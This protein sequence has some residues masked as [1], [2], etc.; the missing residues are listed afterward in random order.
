[1]TREEAQ[2]LVGTRRVMPAT[3]SK[4]KR[5]PVPGTG[6]TVH[7]CLRVD[8]GCSIG[9]NGFAEDYGQAWMTAYNAGDSMWTSAD[10]FASWPLAE[11]GEQTETEKAAR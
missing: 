4:K 8:G 1:M 11:S 5:L 3:L 2:K 9:P 10:D 7:E 6:G